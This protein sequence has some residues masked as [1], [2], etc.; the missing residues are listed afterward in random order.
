MYYKVNHLKNRFQG[1]L[2]FY[3]KANSFNQLFFY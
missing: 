2:L 1:G 3:D